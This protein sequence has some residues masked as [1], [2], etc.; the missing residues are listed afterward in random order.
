MISPQAKSS[1]AERAAFLKAALIVLVGLCIYAPTLRGGW[2]WDDNQEVTENPVL[3]D[4]AGLV[5]IWGGTSGADYFPLKTSVQWLEWRLWGSRPAGYHAVSLALHLLGALLFWRLL[6]RLGLGEAWVGGLL[7]VAHPLAVESVAWVAELKNTLSLPL[8]LLA[9][10][11]YVDYDDRRVRGAYGLSLACF[12]L[13]LLAKSSVVMFPLV[14]LLHAWWRRRR[15]DGRDLAASAPFFALSLGLGLVTVWFQHHRAEQ[16][17]LVLAGGFLSR[18]ACAGLALTFYLGKC[19]WPAGLIPIYPR[20]VVDPPAAWQFAPWLAWGAGAAWLAARRTAWSRAVLF[21]LGFFVLNLLPA[22]GFVT[23]TYM[24]ITWAADHFAYLSLLGVIGLAVAALDRWRPRWPAGRWAAVAL[25]VAVLAGQSRLYARIFHSE[26]TL[27]TYTL[28]RNPAAWS[29][30]YNLANHLAQRHELAAA[31]AHYEQTLRLQPGFADAHYNLGNTF[32]MEGKLAEAVG[33]YE[34]T[35]RLDPNY[36]NAHVG[37]GNVLMQANRLPE[38]MAQ[39]E[40][41]LRLK[42]GF[43]EV[44][45]SLGNALYLSGRFPEAVAQYEEAL[46][47]KPGDFRTESNLETAR[48]AL[49]GGP[50]P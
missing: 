28:Q 8:L 10:T 29:A 48:R 1:G 15:I 6:R 42:P 41:T 43:A 16:A 30:H 44:H 47:L 31:A 38:A 24:R 3:P 45:A 25:A 12:L 22:L 11:A 4:P 19:L 7:F 35:L 14:I 40:E 36:A 46:R 17:E 39:F 20:W 2:L 21:G 50:P 9:M 33:Q 18:L 37:L 32:L 49:R 13:A 5:K 26:E 34:E 27:W 23:N